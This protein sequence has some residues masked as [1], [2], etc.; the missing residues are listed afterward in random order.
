MPLNQPTS[1]EAALRYI[2]EQSL[3]PAEKLGTSELNKLALEV[4]TKAFFSARV[5]NLDFLDRAKALVQD[6]VDGVT[7][8][9][10]AR[11]ELKKL[12]EKLNYQPTPGDEGSIKDLRT[13]RRLNLILD[14]NTDQAR[15]YGSWQRS[16]QP[17][18]VN[19]YPAQE[20][21]RVG[22]IPRAPRPWRRKW[23]DA[24]GRLYDGR[25][26]ALKD[27]SIWTRGIDSGGFNRF[28][29]PYPPYDFNSGMRLRN[30]SRREAI[31]LGVIESGQFVQPQNELGFPEA[32]IQ[33]TSISPEAREILKASYGELIQEQE[34]LRKL[35]A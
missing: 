19:L 2:V 10:S 12:L 24:G 20:L 23:I 3:L 26:I 28:G 4:R 18:L 27:D 17:E 35:Q 30:V 15:N 31:Q 11:T 13:D 7:D 22:P 1:A 25:L 34:N 21:I 5:G 8:R 29:T 16:Q 14:T 32:A 6:Y 33:E 9:A